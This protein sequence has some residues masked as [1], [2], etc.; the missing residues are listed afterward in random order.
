MEAFWVNLKAFLCLLNVTN[1]TESSSRKIMSGFGVKYFVF[2]PHTL[3]HPYY[4][5]SLWFIIIYNI[6][7]SISLTSELYEN[8][9]PALIPLI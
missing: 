1:A 4:E 2:R 9:I 5:P 6:K 8:Y 7:K 3:F